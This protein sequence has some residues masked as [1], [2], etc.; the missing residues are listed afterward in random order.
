MLN[1]KK[2][3][4]AFKRYSKNF[5]EGIK[6]DEVKEQ[7]EER[8]H[9]I[10]NIVELNEIEKDHIL[11]INLSSISSFYFSKWKNDVLI[12]GGRTFDE[13]KKVQKVV[14][15]QCMGQELYITRYPN[16]RVRYT[17]SEVIT[18]LIHFTMFGWEREEKILFDFI[19]KHFGRHLMDVNDENRHIWF[20]LELYLQYR[21]KTIMGTNQNLHLIVI[22]QLKEND[23]EYDLIP[24]SLD[25]YQAVLEQWS[26]QDLELTGNLVEG[27]SL[28]HSKLAA[29]IGSLGEFGDFG[30][31]FYPYEILFLIYV[32]K[33]HGLPV[34]EHF[35][36]FLM[37]TP[38][39]KMLIDDPE[40]YPEW[41]PLL[42]QIDNFY[43]KN[44]PDYI[45]NKHGELF[46]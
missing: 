14:F 35:D 34:P 4:M 6:Y 9:E 38:E 19:I 37:N 10:K 12:N 7:Y 2:L 21:N 24:E 43:R 27:M 15:Y 16:M 5:V 25:V 3:E 30:Y 40:P 31:A 22:E 42:R 26:N 28:Y 33:K 1:E 23:L 32:R 13:L 20:L 41:D 46:R 45:P 11:L 36:D 39:T 17:F 29:E 18:A 44:Y 8:K